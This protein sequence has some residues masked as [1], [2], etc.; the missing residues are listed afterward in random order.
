MEPERGP[1]LLEVKRPLRVDLF[2]FTLKIC[3]EVYA[4]TKS[5]N[6]MPIQNHPTQT[7]G[8]HKSNGAFNKSLIK[9]R[10]S[11]YHPPTERMWSL[12]AQ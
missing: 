1:D 6:I 4:H 5:K 8:R 3:E 2:C 9:G 11:R 10:T 12:S 7:P